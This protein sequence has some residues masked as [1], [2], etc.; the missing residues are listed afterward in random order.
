MIERALSLRLPPGVY[1]NGTRYQ[2]KNRWYDANGVRWYEGIMGPIGGWRNVTS[3]G[4]G[5]TATGAQ[6]S[7]TLKDTTKTWPVNNWATRTVTIVSGLGNGQVRT[8]SSNTVDTLTVSVAWGTTPDSTSVYSISGALLQATGKPR[9]AYGWRANDGISHMGLG[10]HSKLY[11]YTDGVLNDVTPAGMPGGLD[12]FQDG[13]F[14]AG[15]YGSGPFGVGYYGTGS[16]A[17]TLV[18]PSTWT[19]DNFGEILVACHT[20]DGRLVKAN[21][22]GGIATVVDATAPVANTAVV[23]TPEHFIVALGAGGNSRRV[24]WPD[25]ESLSA[26]AITT[27]NQANEFDLPTKGRLVCG[28][29]TRR[30]TILWTDVDVFAMTY[31]GGIDI[32]AFE[33]LGDNCGIIGPQ[34]CAVLGDR[35]FWMSYGKFFEYDGALKPL[36]C[37]VLDEVFGSL[38][39]SQRAKIQAIPMTL[40]NEVWWTYPSKGRTNYENDRYVGYN[41]QEKHWIIGQLPRAA[42]IDRGVYEYP[43]LIDPDGFLFEHEFGANRT[44]MSVFAES[45]PLELGEGD[46]LLRIQQVIPDEKTLGDVKMTLFGAFNP[47]AAELKIGPFIAAQPT[48]TRLT[49]R[50]IRFRVDEVTATDWRVGVP[51]LGVLPAGNR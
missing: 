14:V 39:Q 47:T 45:G 4:E 21:P 34:A 33:Q 42:G 25:Q 49:A 31:V 40:F 51:R 37:D 23:V 11:V 43:V 28:R 12:S 44:G 36:Q 20:V 2:A 9:A 29:R 50:Q 6:T 3:Q 46:Q 24:K 8:I 26:W 18:A 7:T 41:Y 32:Y 5:G 15:N 27:T 38:D 22:G 19:L 16:G 17:L 48:P 35:M 1:K 13:K 30:Q 10:T